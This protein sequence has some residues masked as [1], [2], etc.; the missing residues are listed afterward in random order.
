MGKE[1]GGGN[2]IGFAIKT[3]RKIAD[4]T[5]EQ[6]ARQIGVTHAAISFWENGVNVPNVLDCWRLADVLQTTIDELVGR[7]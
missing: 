4:M 1:T 2:Q 5:Q 6:V 7:V 3:A